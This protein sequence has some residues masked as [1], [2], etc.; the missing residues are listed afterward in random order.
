[1]DLKG[2]HGVTHALWATVEA[3]SRQVM[4]STAAV[5]RNSQGIVQWHVRPP[6]FGREESNPG[7]ANRPTMMAGVRDGSDSHACPGIAVTAAYGC[8]VGEAVAMG[9]TF[10]KKSPIIDDVTFAGTTNCTWC[11]TPGFAAA[12]DTS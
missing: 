1:M 7:P 2:T 8:Q 4:V 3:A 10:S 11:N 12:A 5:S 6:T 9:S